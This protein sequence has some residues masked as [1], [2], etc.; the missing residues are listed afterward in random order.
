VSH[1]HR[2]GSSIGGLTTH[3]RHGGKNAHKA[4]AGL[5]QKLR[6]ECR[7]EI[8]PL[9]TLDRD[10]FERRYQT[11]KRLY[12]QRL[13]QLGI[14]KNRRSRIAPEGSVRTQGTD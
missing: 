8:D 6:A 1:I 7:A 11:F 13:R 10:E 9:N 12:Y 2:L 14:Q 3:L 4:R 5:D